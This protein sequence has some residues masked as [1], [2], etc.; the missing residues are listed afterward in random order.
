MVSDVR[1]GGERGSELEGRNGGGVMKGGGVFG[2]GVGERMPATTLL[3][4]T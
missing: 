2:L 1:C 4:F 3:P